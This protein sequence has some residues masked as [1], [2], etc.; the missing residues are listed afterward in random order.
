MIAG[1][2]CTGGARYCMVG[3]CPQ[4]TFSSTKSGS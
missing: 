2:A 4:K 3:S 1:F